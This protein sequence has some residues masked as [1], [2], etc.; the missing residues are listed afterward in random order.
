MLAQHVNI[1]MVEDNPGDA[2]LLQ[3]YLTEGLRSGYKV[4]HCDRLGEALTF[5]DRETCDII[6][7]DLSL[8][9]SRGL[10]TFLN[11]HT[12]A[13]DIPIVILTGFDD[14]ELASQAMQ[15]GAQ[16]YLPKN[17]LD[18]QQLARTIRYAIER[19]QWEETIRTRE[20][21][22]NR[23]QKMEA[24]GRLSGGIAHNFNNILT[25]I[26]GNCELLLPRVV[27]D[28][29]G[30]RY[31]E[32]IQKA[33]QRASSLTR[34]LMA[35]CRKQPMRPQPV[36]INDVIRDMEQLLH[37]VISKDV[38]FEFQLDADVGAILADPV[39][40]EQVVLNLV[41]NAR[42]AMPN[43]G[44]IIIRTEARDV[45]APIDG[46]P[47]RV[48]AGK[49]VALQVSDTGHGIDPAVLPHIFEPFFTT[50]DDGKGTGLG[51]ATVYGIV[52][53]NQGSIHAAT[54]PGVGTMFTIYLPRQASDTVVA[55]A[56]KPEAKTTPIEAGSE[57]VLLVED[58]AN[59]CSVLAELLGEQG[60]NVL[61]A[62]GGEEA[63]M[64]LNK[65]GDQVGIVVSDIN[66]P[67]INGYEL[68]RRVKQA[69]PA[70]RIVLISG[71]DEDRTSSERDKNLVAAFLP[72]PFSSQTLVKTIRQ[73]TRA[74]AGGK[75]GAGKTA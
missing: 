55:P 26:I 15:R 58:E 7:L 43:G 22:I 16:D 67:G 71:K 9:D 36:M 38:G 57:T 25:A 30:L 54:E 27:S 75:S 23:M 69:R 60:Y 61:T 34:E 47:D 3:E 17:S 33:A 53:Q 24:I 19:K 13:T 74:P 48:P 42:D 28:P 56:A 5:L 32:A 10:P 66:M 63:L 39:Q 35:F 65:H 2:Q 41:L 46:L 45:A 70:C 21:R 73:V 29:R 68:A 8:P 1:L 40:I 62:A 14:A 12:K 37:G 51:L 64:V 50:K 20:E 4:T 44:Q 72:K 59:V 6:L 52:R 49:F 11:L 31:T 18:G